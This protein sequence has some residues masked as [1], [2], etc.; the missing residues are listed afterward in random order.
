MWAPGERGTTAVVGNLLLIGIVV[1]VGAVATIAVLPL[2]EDVD[3]PPQAAVEVDERLVDRPGVQE[4]PGISGERA[5]EVTLTQLEQADTIYV[6]V[7][8][9]GGERKKVVWSDPNEGQV[10]T[11]RLLINDL[12]YEPYWVDIGEDGGSDIAFCPDESAT[13]RFYGEYEGETFLI[14]KY[15]AD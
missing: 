12:E 14:R 1:I 8:D 4:C 11:T 6:I 2:A 13:F 7:A 10:G 15:E 5:L 9:E 3:E